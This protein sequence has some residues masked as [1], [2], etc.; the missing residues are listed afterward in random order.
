[1]WRYEVRVPGAVSLSFHAGRAVLPPGSVLSVSGGG[2]EYRYGP[3]DVRHGELWSRISRGDTLRFLLTVDAA[4]EGAAALDLVAL[5]AGY[6][7]F[8]RGAPNHPH[9]DAIMRSAQSGAA[10][11]DCVENFECHVTADSAGPGQSSVTLVISNLGLCSGV[12]LNDVPGDSIPY[13]L[14]ARHCEN[15]NSDGGEPNAAAGITAYFDAVTPCGQ[16]LG[17]IYSAT[18]AAITG[19]VTIVE[20][21]DAWLIRM[22]DSV[23][24]T[25]AYFSGWD[26]TGAAFVGGYTAHYALGY[27][28]QYVGWYGQA[29]YSQVPGATLG[30]HYTSTFWEL[31]NQLGSTA[32]GA[33]GS[34]VFDSNGRMVGT[35]VR[36]LAQDSQPG[37][38]GVCPMVAPD[39]PST[40]TA[41]ADATAFSGIFDSTADSQSTTGATTLRSV[42]DPHH[43]GVLILAGRWSPPQFT[44]STATSSSGSLVTLTWNAPGAANCTA[45][46]GQS[47]DGWSGLLP[48]S[49]TQA[50]TEYASGAVTYTLNCAYSSQQYSE[51]VTVNWALAAPAA[52]ITITSVG[53]RFAGVPLQLNWSST[54]TPC[55]ASG[56]GTGDGWAGTLA[57]QGTATVNESAGGTYT[58]L[59]NCGSGSR[60]AS[61]QVQVTLVAPTAMLSDNGVTSVNIGLPVT[62]NWNG[63][64]LHCATSGG[65]ATDGWATLNIN[66][67][68]GFSTI[69]ETTP[70]T[71]T[72]VFSCSAGTS[73]ATSSVTVTFTSGPPAV[74]LTTSLDAPMVSQSVLQVSWFATVAPCSLAVSG[75]SNNSFSN[76]SYTGSQGDVEAVIGPYTYTVTCGSGSNTVSASK[77]VNWGGAPTLSLSAGN[78]PILIGTPYSVSWYGNTVPCVASGGTQGDGWSGSWTQPYG[79]VIVA[80]G[81]PGTYTYLL[82]CGTG[83]QTIQAQAILVINAGSAVATL[84][85][86]ATTAALGGLPVTLTWNSN[87]SPC[88]Q[89]TTGLIETDGWGESGANA[90]TASVMEWL[91]GSYTYWI[92]CGGG[93]AVGASAQVTV[94]FTGPTRPTFTT[95]TN[96]A[97]VGQPFTLSWASADGST[98]TPLFGAPGDGWTG[99]LPASGTMQIIEVIPGP[100]AYEIKCGVAALALLG[101]EVEPASIVPQPGVL[102]SVQIGLSHTSMFPGQN[103]MLIWNSS[104]TTG[105]SASGGSG[106]DGWQGSVATVGSQAIT[107]SIA[108]S[109]SFSISCTGGNPT[110][111]QAVLTV[112]PAPTAGMSASATSVD[113]GQPFTLSWSSTETSGCTAGGGTS[114][115]G[116]AGSEATSGS[117]SITEAAAGSY[118]YTVNCSAGTETVQAMQEVVVVANAS[119]GGHGG[120]GPL[121]ALSLAVLGLLA[122][123]RE[124]AGRRRCRIW[125]LSAPTERD[126]PG[127]AM[128]I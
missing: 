64:G 107:E 100:Y 84:T 102:A 85:A 18:T 26:A 13:V 22:D 25:D 87:T 111:G 89:T 49:G 123:A 59:L 38:P 11:T 78:S 88:L 39:A 98:C 121:D 120:G 55:T 119:G 71:Y 62:L 115:D 32:P 97:N 127:T 79:S 57:G 3:G 9:Y 14:T 16:A 15:G 34:G 58:Y 125:T 95:S 46:G 75:Y 82:T 68:G 80:E 20:Q 108:G 83:S 41:T 106:S 54:V 116:W 81:H 2:T 47:G 109:Y 4:D 6:R 61:A 114:G 128:Y 104:G 5:Q 93:G 35:I 110:T 28:R 60:T 94:T 67:A 45:S 44:A 65:V 51:Q 19:A 117:A 124:M 96:Y 30:V 66:Y 74:T 101:V 21:Q 1:M 52:T 126:S 42:L 90:G 70:G 76:L 12:L 73:T 31:V 99:T 36:G 29:Y 56:G 122:S 113:A 8:A 69:S 43:S 17:S 40:T 37:S 27:T 7:S 118:T 105:C 112:N 72:Y 33:S 24:V 91:P 63:S 92:Q 103:T 77:T 50:L 23:P 53:Q 10:Q 48:N 86:S